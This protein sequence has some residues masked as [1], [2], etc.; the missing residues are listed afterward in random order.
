MHDLFIPSLYIE[1]SSQ[2]TVNKKITTMSKSATGEFK[3]GKMKMKTMKND[4][5]RKKGKK[6]SHKKISTVKRD[7]PLGIVRSVW[8]PNLFCQVFG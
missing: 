3:N 8:S 7:E 6:W 2:F 4:Y 1:F 5:K